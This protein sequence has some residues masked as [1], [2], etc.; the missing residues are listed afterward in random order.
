MSPV[1]FKPTISAGE[2]LQNSAIG[3]P[4]LG[5]AL[6]RYYFSLLDLFEVL[7]NYVGRD[8]SV[9]IATPCGLD[10]T[11]IESRWRRDFPHLS[12]LVLGPYPASCTIGTGSFPGV[13]SGRG[14][15]LTP[16]PLLVAL[17]MKE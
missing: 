12:R 7:I 9:G 4:P 13:K 3:G 8:S 11:G 16:H 2:R 17:V 1:G 6:G 15:R 5:P 14:V 10:G